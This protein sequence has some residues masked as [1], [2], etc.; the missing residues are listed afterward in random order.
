MEQHI[1]IDIRIQPMTYT[2][3]CDGVLPSQC[4]DGQWWGRQGPLMIKVLLQPIFLFPY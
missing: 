1:L 2:Q 3:I 4:N